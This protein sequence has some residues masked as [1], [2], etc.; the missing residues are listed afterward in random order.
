MV[1]PRDRVAV[2]EAFVPAA[3]LTRG[4]AASWGVMAL[5]AVGLVGGS[6]LVADRLGAR[7]VR[8]SAA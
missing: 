6:V 7:V 1:L 8:S 5:L 4:V 3:D 2:V